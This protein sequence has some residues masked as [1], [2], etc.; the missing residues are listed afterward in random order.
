[1][2]VAPQWRSFLTQVQFIEW[3][4]AHLLNKPI[5]SLCGYL[6]VLPG[7]FS[8]YRWEAIEVRTV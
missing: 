6:T 8:G 5:E 1:M 2:C 3:K 4:V 7:A